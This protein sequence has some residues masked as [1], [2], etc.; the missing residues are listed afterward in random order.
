[1]KKLYSLIFM[2]ASF[3]FAQAQCVISL[4][5]QADGNVVTATITGT[6]AVVP[7]YTIDWGDGNFENAATGVH[8][9]ADP[10]EYTIT[11]VY[12][13]MAPP[14]CSQTIQQIVAITGGGCTL[15]FNPIAVGL[16]V[17]LQATSDN[18]SVPTYSINWGD[19]SPTENTDQGLHVYAAAGT[20]DICV[21]MT[22]LDNPDFCTLIQCETITVVEQS[23][24]CT[25]DLTV[26]VDGTTVN[27]TAVGTGAAIENY[28]I[29]WGDNTISN[30]SNATHVYAAT[31]EYQV[32]VYYG[33]LSPDGCQ[34][35]D[36]QT[37]T[38][39][40]G[41]GDCTLEISVNILGLVAAVTANGVGATDPVYTF[42]WGDNTAPTNDVP[43]IHTYTQPGTYLIC[44]SYMDMDNLAGC[45]VNQCQEVTIEETTT[46]CT[47]DLTVTTNGYEV[48]ANAVGVGATS[49]QYA[50]TWGV[51]G[52]LPTVGATGS[53]TYDA[54][55]AY[56]VCV[57]YVDVDNIFG[58]NVT[59]CETVNITVG[60]EENILQGG[61]LNVS[62]NPL[63]DNSTISLTLNKAAEI[64]IN[65]YDLV[66]N[67]VDNVM[68]G[69]R[70]QG[71]HRLTWNTSTMSS[72]I[73]FVKIKANNEEKTIKVIR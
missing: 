43:G 6:G 16:L 11:A 57:T 40:A 55:G 3:G 35:S 19:G 61:S 2:L 64:S 38:A 49:P 53:Y 30:S 14:Y 26:L 54:P 58:C 18:T 1:M 24:D 67:L 42:D 21:T 27:A 63:A 22:D 66:G 29:A 23:G 9:Y 7:F 46:D 71:V 31:G 34:V 69:T 4:D 62:P 73:Y 13:D 32:C 25:V 20:Y 33:D 48:T 41:S 51:G 60:V 56:E 72:G 70:G 15:N 47:V 52:T 44:V 8:T 68:N 12:V 37:I 28:I 50:I 59:Q 10:G 5:V 65:V 39:E 36:C 45:Q 17:T